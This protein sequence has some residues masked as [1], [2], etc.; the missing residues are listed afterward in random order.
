MPLTL[1]FDDNGKSGASLDRPALNRL[2]DAIAKGS[3]QRVVVH[4]FDRLTRSVSDF[5]R[6]QALL[7]E[8]GVGL[9]VVHGEFSEPSNALG[10]F[11]M[12][13]L[14]T[15]AQF[16]REIIAERIR[17]GREAKRERGLRI[18]GLAPFGYA[19]HLA[20]TVHWMF[21][22]ADGGG[23]PAEIATIASNWGDRN[24]RGESGAWCT[25]TVLRILATRCTQA[26]WPM[27]AA[28]CIRPSWMLTCSS[29]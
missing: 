6:L 25:E 1:P 7:K 29:A 9:S 16:E 24:R 12:N 20:K 14:A 3:V 28:V 15:F 26:G 2:L 10:Q 4:R 17:D 21:A 8:R 18:A 19:I 23:T 22:R 5:A 13:V 27:D 11:Q